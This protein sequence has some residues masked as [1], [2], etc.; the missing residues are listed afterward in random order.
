M[1]ACKYP[2]TH[3]SQLAADQLDR[4]L[5]LLGNQLASRLRNAPPI[6]NASPY[7]LALNAIN[8]DRVTNFQWDPWYAGT[9]AK[10]A[11]ASD[12]VVEDEYSQH[13]LA[14]TMRTH[15]AKRHSSQVVFP[16]AMASRGDPC[17]EDELCQPI[18]CGE[19]VFY[20]LRYNDDEKSWLQNFDDLLCRITSAGYFEI[21]FC[22]ALLPPGSREWNPEQL[23][24]MIDAASC[25][26]SAAL[27]GGGY[28]VWEL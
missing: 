17:L 26:F 21:G 4:N 13:L 24:A 25:I 27:D 19:C 12:P 22:T 3:L 8:L 15:V 1:H 2:V 20:T 7:L 10:T 5:A 16:D 6:K 18:Y 14:R 11:I 28:L 9:D 23:T